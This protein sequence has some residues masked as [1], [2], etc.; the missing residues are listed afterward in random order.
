MNRGLAD[1]AR[2]LQQYGRGPDTMLAHISP[3]EAAFVD[4]LQGGRRVNPHT[5]LAEYGLF[6]KVLKGLARAAGAAVGFTLGGPAGA[7]L[8]AGLATK[9]TGGSWKDAAIGAALAGGGAWAGNALSGAGT[10]LTTGA[11]YGPLAA[12]NAGSLASAGTSSLGA[13]GANTATEGLMAGLAPAGGSAAGMSLGGLGSATL[14]TVKAAPLTYAG[15]AATEAMRPNTVS[16][17]D[18]NAPPDWFQN[19]PKSPTLAEIDTDLRSR[20]I[21]G[22]RRYVPYTGD[23]Y[24]YRGHR[25]FEKVAPSNMADGGAVLPPQQAVQY[26]LAGYAMG[27]KKGGVVKGA[28]DGKSDDIP[29][30]LSQ[31][32]HIVDA[33]TVAA[34]GDGSSDA[35]HKRMEKIKQMIRA[36]A[37]QKNPKKPTNKQKSLGSMLATAKAA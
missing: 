29:A 10:G 15:L 27:R 28:G 11:S 22:Q 3:Q 8:G 20:G 17:K 30:M 24:N 1:T 5:G 9:A 16:S 12:S 35:G 25:F 2:E 33:Q 7:A 32:E 19:A 18:K 21:T 23:P 31:D 36:S 14:A 26:G 37:G 13:V 34:L 6:G 4:S